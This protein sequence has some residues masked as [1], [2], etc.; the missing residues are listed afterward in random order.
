MPSANTRD[1]GL[2]FG[3]F[4]AVITDSLARKLSALPSDRSASIVEVP[5]TVSNADL[6]W[7]V[8]QQLTALLDELDGAGAEK[9][10]RQVEILNAL[11][12]EARQQHA[13]AVDLIRQPPQTLKAIKPQGESAIYP[14]TGL[15]HPWL[16]TASKGNPSLL[17]E[18]R[19]ESSDCDQIDLLI[20]FITVSGVRKMLDLLEC[21]ARRTDAG[22]GPV[23]IRVL[24]T[25]YTGATEM[26]A[27]NMLAR[28]PGC[29]VR[30][31]LDGRRSRLHAKAWV[32][33]RQTGFGSAY[34]GSANFSAA[35]LLGGLEWT[36]KLTEYGQRDLFEKAKAHFETLWCDR[37]FEP[38]DPSNQEHRL[39]LSKAL[40]REE[41]FDGL[42]EF[43][44]FELRPKQYQ[45][46]MLDTLAAERAHHR[47][48]NLV[49]AATGTGKTVVAAFD[50]RARC[51]QAETAGVRPRLL[52]V[53]H[54]EEILRQSLHTFRMVLRDQSFGDL[55]VGGNE[56]ASRDY[57]FASIQSIG[58][59]NLLA[60]VVADYWDMVIVDECH[61]LAADSF[62]CLMERVRPQVLLGLT[63]TPERG[64]GTS[65]LPFFQNRLDGSPA[66][67]MRLWH[68]L[69]LQ[70]LTPFDYFA[71]DD[72]TDFASVPWQRQNERA[73]LDKLL[74]G[75]QARAQI[76]IDEWKRLSGDPRQS[77]AIAFC[78][79]VEHAQFMAK[80]FTLAGIPA[81]CV[82]GQSDAE[83][84]RTAPGRLSRREINVITTCDIYNEGVDIP[85]VDTLLLLRPTQSPVVFQQQIGRGLRLSEDTRKTSCLILD[86]VGRHNAEF[87]FDTLFSRLTGM[88]RAE[89]IDAVEHEFSTLP[90]GCH[91]HLAKQAREQVLQNLRAA[92]QQNW[93]R[94][95]AELRT[96]VATRGRTNVSL[97]DFIRDQALN[98]EDVY[99]GQGRSG[100]ASLQ[101][102]AGILQ[103]TPSPEEEKLGQRYSDLLH[104]DDPDH[105]DLIQLVAEPTTSYERLTAEDRL[106]LQMVTYQVDGQSSQ[107]GSG[108]AFLERLQ[109]NP[110][111]RSDLGE[112][113]KL[114]ASQNEILPHPIPG[115]ADTPLRLHAHY[116]SREVLTAVGYHTEAR[117]TPFRA[118]VLPLEDRKVEFLFVT[119]DKSE[120]L[121]AAVAYH[122]YAISPDRFHWQ[123]QNTAGPETKAG[124]R[125]LGSPEN[126]WR[127]QLMV[128][129]KKGDA[130]CAMG[131]VTIEEAKGTKPMSIVWRMAVPMPARLFSKF[132]VLR[133]V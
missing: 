55:F 13:L 129:S 39:A 95:I 128:R 46:S 124:Q 43:T 91:I 89:L 109:N 97:A 59:R 76:I 130:Y 78:V 30:V 64:D 80:C 98:I 61:H 104:I 82:S 118:G 110:A 133:A 11:L 51:Q 48:R 116:S 5:T 26:E 23:R 52:F 47:T 32:F 100:W 34:V 132:S 29:E 72:P 122:D 119:L 131:P 74:T 65:I 3:L 19:T 36:V 21:A 20:S 16:F 44:F 90:A 10:R 107:V 102:D 93:R 45:Q 79:S 85:S 69:D 17:S 4:D 114:L 12:R 112:L 49:V 77:R 94:L 42:P 67:E 71:C 54:R 37:E 121:H 105:L 99:R 15:S 56:P 111:S 57:L 38:Y 115:L 84:R 75:N 50:Y 92:T 31:S 24:T 6:A 2:P 25:T 14:V 1:S 108:A 113:A 70:L 125:Y 7:Q 87:R 88:T 96:Y 28:L 101:R 106:R 18:L 58:S 83:L 117:R 27:L 9:A 103:G 63:A 33:H 81:E 22:R 127:F 123:S 73:T 120:A 40:K 35:A 53:A 68:A 8:A 60:S 62:Q 41:G 66:V 126:G 86:F